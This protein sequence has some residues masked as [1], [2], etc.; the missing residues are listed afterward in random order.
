M[1][2]KYFGFLIKLCDALI[3]FPIILFFT[4][5]C[6]VLIFHIDRI[7]ELLDYRD[8]PNLLMLTTGILGITWAILRRSYIIESFAFI[9]PQNVR[10]IIYFI[11]FFMLMYFQFRRK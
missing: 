11:I 1:L 2:K 5:I 8:V 7:S 9:F 3:V 6:Y 10:Q 4:F